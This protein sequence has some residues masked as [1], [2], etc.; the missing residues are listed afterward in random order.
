MSDLFEVVWTVRMKVGPDTE[1]GLT[2]EDYG[3]DSWEQAALLTAENFTLD[4]LPQLLDSDLK[5]ST[6][7]SRR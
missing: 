1:D 3:V 2:L 5:V 7:V 6:R 4:D